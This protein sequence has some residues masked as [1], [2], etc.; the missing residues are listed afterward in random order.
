MNLFKVVRIAILLLFGSVTLMSTE[1]Q[2]KQSELEA[3]DDLFKEGKFVEAEKLYAKVQA[4]EPANFQ[5]ALRLGSI[6]LLAN[7]LDDAQKWLAKATELKPEEQAPKSLMAEVFYRRDD[8]ERAAPFFRA[9]GQEA[10]AKKLES[11]K[12]IPACQIEG[13]AEVS[14]LKFVMT[15]P[16]PVI[17]VRVNE[18]ES[19][20][21]FI[22][23]GGAEVIVD[24]ELAKELK[25][26]Q[27]GSMTGTFAGGKQAPF[28][29]G[30]LDVLTLGEFTVKNIPVNIMDVRRFS[31]PVFG[32]KQM[33]GII[34]TVLLYHFIPTLDYPQGEL[35]LR[36]RTKENLKQVEQEAQAKKDIVIPFWM[37][38]DHYMVAWGT[39]NKS[40]P[41][42]F[43][44]DTG[45]AGGGFTCPESTIKEAGINLQESLAAEGVGGGGKVKVVP[46]VVEE[47][48]LGDAKEHDVNGFYTG[49]FPLENAFRFRIG[50]LISH[51]FF[52][53]YALTLDFAGMRY[54]LE[55]K[56]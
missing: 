40:Q 9:R 20:N 56:E 18:G 19:V 11:F 21:F 26:A 7:R 12:G 32:G 6:S 29:H 23:T 2:S 13:K 42:L 47:L 30:R 28:Q 46:F 50:G 15:D 27:F 54:Y 38:G 36:R 45:L 33:D 48:T 31:Q 53:P 14:H 5:A 25:I 24:T 1:V 35:V 37:A 34:G 10:V 22:D 39:V 8:F 49:A 4:A 16:L 17:Q 51:A 52:R 55:R 43:F 44:V 3:A 41:L